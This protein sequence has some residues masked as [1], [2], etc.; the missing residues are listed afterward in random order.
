MRRLLPDVPGIAAEGIQSSKAA[1]G[2]F[3]LSEAEHLRLVNDHDSEILFRSTVVV[4]PHKRARSLC[5]ESQNPD[6][7]AFI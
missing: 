1:R 5:G 4:S 2:F 6:P 7:G 3:A